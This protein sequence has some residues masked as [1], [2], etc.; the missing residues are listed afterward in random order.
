MNPEDDPEA[1]IRALEQPLADTARASELGGPQPGGYSSQPY[2][3][4]APPPPPLYG[5]YNAGGYNSG[6]GPGY[7]APFAGATPRRSSGNRVFWILAAVFVVGMLAVVG[8]IAAYVAHRISSSN[9]IVEP[10]TPDTSVFSSPRSTPRS[11]TPS[12]RTKTPTAGPSTPQTSAAP[13]PGSNLSIAG[14]NQNRTVACNDNSV[15]V[16]GVSNTITISGHCT[17]VT[18]SGMQNT[19]T[20]DAVD[21]IDASGLNNQVTYHSGSP[22]ISKSGDGNVVQQG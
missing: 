18:V 3:P 20:V 12:T 4:P 11:P 9:V 16:S 19:V 17:K 1:R 13:A 10:S 5:D 2:P 8:G 7:N 22:Q 21:T 15:T 14:I 6:F